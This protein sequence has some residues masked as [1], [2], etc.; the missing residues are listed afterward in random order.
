MSNYSEAL[1]FA[2]AFCST[3]EHCKS[4]VLD[5]TS[6][7]ELNPEEQ[8]KLIQRL[9]QEGFL[10]EKRYV[11]AFVGDRFRFN[12]WGKVKIRYALKQKRV[13]NE[14]IDEGMDAIPD[15]D[16]KEMLMTLLRQ[17]RPSI[18]SKTNYE[19][20]GKMIRFAV[21]RG[22]ESALITKCLKEMD[23]DEEEYNE[24]FI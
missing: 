14:L 24:D 10:N 1:A 17:K 9:Q 7:F 20:S 16:Y 12:K 4:E 8:S 6:K 18:K 11:K 5:K 13:S 22:F 21:G 3:A 19:L 15:E 23:I 2:A